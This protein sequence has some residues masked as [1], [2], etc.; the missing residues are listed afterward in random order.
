MKSDEYL[1]SWY[2]TPCNIYIDEKTTCTKILLQPYN[3]IQFLKKSKSV[4]FPQKCIYNFLKE[5]KRKSMQGL[6]T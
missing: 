6:N 2:G 4:T 5:I 1:Y 3:H